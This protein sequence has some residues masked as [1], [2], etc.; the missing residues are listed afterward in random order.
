MLQGI[1]FIFDQ[2]FRHMQKLTY[3]LLI[4]VIITFY[5]CGDKA[6][7][8]KE[9][10]P[11]KNPLGAMMNMA[12]EMEENAKKQEERM[13]KGDSLKAIPYEELY[14]YLPE[15]IDGYK[16]GEPTGATM[17]M[18][19]LSYSSA[20]VAYKNDNGDRV[21]ISIIDYSAAFS[22]YTMSTAMWGMGMSVDTPEEKGKSITVGDMKGWESFK[23]K[24][25]KASVVLGAG[26][27]F[28]VAVDADKQENTDFVK[29]VAGKV[30]LKSLVSL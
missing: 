4:L 10:D 19:G 28:L 29:S 21:K 27:R 6:E 7:E 23:K 22:L 9:I 14:K 1:N 11:K 20:E 26:D 25:K 16:K 18:Q 3:L 13:A 15:S 12:K 17:T 8:K 5:S 30:D 24:S 2:Q